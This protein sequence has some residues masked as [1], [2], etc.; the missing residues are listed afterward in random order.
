[1]A[2]AAAF[3]VSL[4]LV[5]PAPVPAS[6]AG[7]PASAARARVAVIG[8]SLTVGTLIYGDPSHLR[9]ALATTTVRLGPKPSA[10][11]GRKVSQGLRILAR[12]DRLPRVVLVELG[13]NNWRAGSDRAARWIARARAALGPSRTLY[14]VNLRMVGTR[15]ER[16]RA[17]N[18]GLR[19]GVAADNRRAV[20][21]G[22]SGRSYVLDWSRYS[23]RMGV[24]PGR[25][26]IHYSPF[27]YGVLARFVAGSLDQRPAY[28]A[29]RI[30]RAWP[31]RES[32]PTDSPAPAPLP[33]ATPPLDA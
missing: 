22:W 16:H 6:P 17:V 11:V 1:V 15:Y 8:D 2:L 23:R 10:R 26:G 12:A 32:V 24:A 30:P 20:A 19:R 28:A 7:T 4:V 18:A 21:S 5:L 3:G 25:D 14:W 9:R 33:T 31:T 29:F 13:T 27:G